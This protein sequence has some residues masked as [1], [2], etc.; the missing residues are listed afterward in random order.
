M[1]RTSPIFVLLVSAIAAAQTPADLAA[2]ARAVLEKNCAGYH[3]A[4]PM[5]GLNVRARAALLKGGKRG[6]ALV[7]GSPDQS[8]L[9][10]AVRRKGD[11][12]MPPGKASLA[13][14]DVETLRAWISAGA[15][16]PGGPAGSDPSWWSFRPPR[17][18]DVPPA[19]AAPNPIDAFIASKLRDKKLR[20][21]PPAA[22]RTLIRR[23]YFDLHGL[24]PSPEEVEQF[25]NDK[26]A[27]SYEM[28]L[29]RLLASPRYGERWGRHWLDVVRYA[30]TGGFET[31]IYFPNAWRYR[32]YVIQSFNDDKPY[33][34]FV[35]EQIA[36]DELWPDDLELDG[37]G[38]EIPKEKK[39]HLEA[40]IGTGM[41]TIGPV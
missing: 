16:W 39:R 23:A 12:Q 31:D 15:A 21:A 2:A 9:M 26:S 40:R 11:L 10:Q 22:R 25:V 8:L 38:F 28:L 37:N 4:A 35:Q 27:N 13:A 17:R 14:S 19:P 24:P 32:D 3:G 5:T 34:R 18:P 29:D 20:P 33:D 1:L 6:P 7:A 36:G 41:Y 30:D